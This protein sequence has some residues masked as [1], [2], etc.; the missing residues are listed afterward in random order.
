MVLGKAAPF[1]YH[2]WD[3]EFIDNSIKEND[4][5]KEISDISCMILSDF[6]IPFKIISESNQ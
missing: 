6:D 5:W 1:C 3:A 2:I 4:S